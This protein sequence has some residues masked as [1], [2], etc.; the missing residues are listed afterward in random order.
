VKVLERIRPHWRKMTWVLIIWSALMLAWIINAGVGADCSEQVGQY[1]QAKQS[2]CEAGT[3]IGIGLLITLWFMG[4]V[5][6]GMVWF[7]TRPKTS[8][9]ASTA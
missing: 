4:F 8:R 7:M 6:L 2:G 1:Q 9:I 5:V 3:G